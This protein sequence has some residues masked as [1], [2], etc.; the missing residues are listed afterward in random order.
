MEFLGYSHLT[1]RISEPLKLYNDPNTKLR[2]KWPKLN[3]QYYTKGILI[4][5]NY[6]N[7]S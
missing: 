7:N 2:T 3:Y 6:R 5:Q 4:F 1:G